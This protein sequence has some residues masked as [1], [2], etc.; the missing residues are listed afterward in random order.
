MCS[1]LVEH[2]HFLSFCLPDHLLGVGNAKV[3]CYADFA[4]T[5]TLAWLDAEHIVRL[6]RGGILRCCALQMCES[7]CVYLQIVGV[8]LCE[9]LECCN[10]CAILPPLD[11]A[12]V[13]LCVV[14]DVHFH[15][16][17]ACAT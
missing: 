15:I 4:R 9:L 7:C 10:L 13:A 1:K 5:S 14:L 8:G 11:I 6:C 12:P 16:S 3:I 2:T 17:V